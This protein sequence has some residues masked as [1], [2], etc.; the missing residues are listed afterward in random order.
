MG[1]DPDPWIE[2]AGEVVRIWS[3]GGITQPRDPFAIEL[4]RGR[5]AAELGRVE[6]ELRAFLVLVTDWAR[7]VPFSNPA[8]LSCKLGE[9]FKITRAAGTV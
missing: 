1:H 6:R 7:A 4:E 2:W 5:F 9:C 3:G 8:A